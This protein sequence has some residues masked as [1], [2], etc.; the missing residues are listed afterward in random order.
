MAAHLI[1]N[2]IHLSQFFLCI[3]PDGTLLLGTSSL[4]GRCWQGSL[5]IYS[6]P[7]KAP[8]E[9]LCKAG[10]QTEAGVVDA[11][12]VS[13]KGVVVASD[14][15]KQQISE[16][17]QTY[18]QSWYFSWTL[19]DRYTAGA[20]ELWELAENEHLLVN[21]FTKHDHDNIVTTVSPVIGSSGAVTGSMDCRWGFVILVFI[22]NH[23]SNDHRGTVLPVSSFLDILFDYIIVSFHFSCP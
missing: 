9:E 7:R 6:D 14:S 13:D 5:W 21:R 23:S 1:C 12:W 22:S 10:V 4:G 2:L 20:L 19:F 11:K 17:W 15:G 16:Q 8:N 3:C 18:H